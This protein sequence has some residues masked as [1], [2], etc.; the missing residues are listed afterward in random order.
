MD[1]TAENA[2]ANAGALKTIVA[3][4]STNLRI[5]HDNYTQDG[6]L[7]KHAAEFKTAL[8]TAGHS[9][10]ELETLTNEFARA[11]DTSDGNIAKVLAKKA[12]IQKFADITDTQVGREKRKIGPSCCLGEKPE[13][14]DC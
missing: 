8:Q 14:Q 4:L 3:D 7:Y 2:K 12:D 5:F 9:F 13:Q 11:V 1:K 6:V 10:E